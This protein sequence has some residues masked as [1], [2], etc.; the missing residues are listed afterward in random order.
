MTKAIGAS[1]VSP[2]PTRAVTRMRCFALGGGSGWVDARQLSAADAVFL[3]VREPVKRTEHI[4]SAV[5]VPGGLLDF[6]ADPASPSHDDKL[7]PANRENSRS[8]I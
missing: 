1:P 6:A 7:N 2:G 3:D 4:T 5:Q 8:P